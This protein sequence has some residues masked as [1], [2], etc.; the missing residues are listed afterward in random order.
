M[1]TVTTA[2]LIILSQAVWKMAPMWCPMLLVGV[3]F[4]I[5]EN[6]ND[7]KVEK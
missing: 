2:N 4:A 3:G 1:E 7:Y 5:W 6:N